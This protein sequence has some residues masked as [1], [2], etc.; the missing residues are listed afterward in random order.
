MFLVVQKKNNAIN[1][2][3]SGPIPVYGARRSQCIIAIGEHCKKKKAAHVY[4]HWH[5]VCHWRPENEVTSIKFMWEHSAHSFF[6]LYKVY[7]MKCNSQPTIQSQSLP[8]QQEIHLPTNSTFMMDTN[9]MYSH[10]YSSLK[11]GGG[12]PKTDTLTEIQWQWY[13]YG[14]GFCSTL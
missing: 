8:Y 12:V 6:L 11:H 10:N 1:I 7:F 13:L 14:S 2:M 5:Q 4:E 9:V 3:F